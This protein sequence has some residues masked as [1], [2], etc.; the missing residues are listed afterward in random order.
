M[1]TAT[2]QLVEILPAKLPDNGELSDKIYYECGFCGKREGLYEHARKMCEK[3]SG[4]DYYCT[5]CLSKGFH[6]KNNRNILIMSFR[7]IIGYYYYGLYVNP[8]NPDNILYLSQIE[9]YVDAHIEA[10]L[11]NPIF[12][13][14]H[15]TFLWFIDFSR[16]GR[17]RK[18]VKYEEILKTVANILVCFNLYHHIQ[19]IKVATLYE[20]YEESVR[21]FQETRYRPEG[22]PYLIPT[23][24]SCTDFINIS[25]AFTI[26]DT[27]SFTLDRM[28][29][30]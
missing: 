7:A 30:I 21:K 15:Q 9:D 27:R 26:E 12:S 25:K 2:Q 29:F 24:Q 6:T 20:K 17:D 13:Y 19:R 10:G 18:K 5:F 3:L 1:N 11:Q 23:L 14:D 16:V 28:V 22:K 4:N 8:T